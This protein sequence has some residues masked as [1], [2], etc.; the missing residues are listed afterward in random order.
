MRIDIK[1]YHHAWHSM[2]HSVI[3][4]DLI[5]VIPVA[6]TST[7]ITKE[8]TTTR[9]LQHHREVPCPWLPPGELSF[10]STQAVV[11]LEKQTPSKFNYSLLLS[12]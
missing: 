6:A 3:V 8:K 7:T 10:Y 9:K 4:I 5:F 2:R 11:S 1:P 12:P